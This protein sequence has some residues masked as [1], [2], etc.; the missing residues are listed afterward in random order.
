M[1]PVI[2]LTEKSEDNNNISA[3]IR[4]ANS[5]SENGPDDDEL[6]GQMEEELEDKEE[7]HL[8]PRSYKTFYKVALH[9]VRIR[10]R[11]DHIYCALCYD[12]LWMREERHRMQFYFDILEN[13]SRIQAENLDEELDEHKA[14]IGASKYKDKENLTKEMRKLDTQ[15]AH[16]ERHKLLY[17]TA[18]KAVK[19]AELNLTPVVDSIWYIDYAKYYAS[20]GTH[21]VEWGLT[22]VWKDKHNQE[23][24]KHVDVF[25]GEA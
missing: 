3:L 8:V 5:S 6:F 13:T 7:N 4:A 16:R 15:I 25:F 10:K 19:Q 20:N 2:K 14:F 9:G 1:K 23:F 17:Q 12:L 22:I 24:R 21:V 11:P 18:R